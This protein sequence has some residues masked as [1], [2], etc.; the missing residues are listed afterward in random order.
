MKGEATASAVADARAA[1][2]KAKASLSALQDQQ[3]QN[4]LDLD[5]AAAFEATALA[6][7]ATANP[8][9]PAD[10]AA[11]CHDEAG[12]LLWRMFL[13]AAPSRKL[14]RQHQLCQ[15]LRLL[16]TAVVPVCDLFELECVNPQ[17]M[18]G[19]MVETT[20]EAIAAGVLSTALQLLSYRLPLH[21]PAPPRGAVDSR[22]INEAYSQL[23][24][25][26]VPEPQP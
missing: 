17:G 4:S 18:L 5:A 23:L 22:W 3:R 1:L 25:G 16:V 9:S 14:Q 6:R 15:D 13:A 11:F 24:K 20:V 10:I 12:L 8:R 21:E 19:H 26:A 7:R 2:A